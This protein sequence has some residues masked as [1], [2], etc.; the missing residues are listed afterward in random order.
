MKINEIKGRPR[1]S[2]GE[3][4]GYVLWKQTD[5]FHLRW[6]TEGEKLYTFKGKIGYQTKLKVTRIAKPES[7]IKIVEL[8]ENVIEW[9]S[10]EKGKINGFDFITPGN[11]TLELKIN[12][13]TIKPKNILL[14]SQKLRPENNPFTITQITT[15]E[16]HEKEMIRKLKAKDNDIVKEIEPE[17]TFLNKI[18]PTYEPTP[19]PE[20]EPEPE[21]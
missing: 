8:E 16:N 14:G 6:N 5:G 1:F 4:L 15:E 19:E 20:P 18:E 9:V 21:P 17:A 3:F 7:R 2:S 10:L 12:N 13:K 11:F